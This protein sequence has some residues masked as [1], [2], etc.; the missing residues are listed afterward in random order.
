LAR[1]RQSVKRHRTDAAKRLRNKMKLSRLRTAVRR[2]REASSPEEKDR[3]WRNAQS[4]LDR[5]GRTRLIHP[6]RVK[7]IKSSLTKS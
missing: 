3:A 1:S 5:A 7:R 6:N 4:L 2:V